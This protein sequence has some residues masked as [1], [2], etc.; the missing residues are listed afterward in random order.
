MRVIKAFGPRDLR[1]VEAPAPLSGEGE[2]LI[3]VRASGICGS[4]K[5]F[6][7]EG[8]PD[9]VAGH[10]VAG[11]VAAL[12]PGAHR[13]R[14]GDRV[15]VNNVVG[16]GR[17][18]ECRA[19]RFVRCPRRPGTDVNNGFGE[20]LTAP[21]RNC[22]LL[23]ERLCYE[24][25]CLIFDN[26][27]TPYAAL[28]A[29]GV[30]GGDD[31]VVSGCGPIGLAAVVLAK[32]RGAFV[33]AADPLAYRRDAALRLGADVV[34]AP[35]DGLPAAVRELTDGAGARV[36]LECSGKGDA[37]EAGLSCLRI[38][39]VFVAVGEG[40]EYLLRP[41]DLLIRRHLVLLGSWYTTMADGRA[42]QDLML[43]GGFD[44]SAFVTHRVSL[45]EVPEAMAR[46]CTCADEVLKTVI[47]IEK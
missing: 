24:A 15:A 4:D 36:L 40:A 32:E 1:L 12:G 18:A 5:W 13:L 17:C 28:N 35:D 31:L 30:V 8:P 38:G 39:G 26:W 23:D 16:C 6:W 3:E 27:G 29:A 47:L 37:Y 41:S 33:I 9:T 14:V 2:V 11:T 43:R 34:L 20:L 21:E 7:R 25:G 19:G 42:V 44:P 46:V 45:P 10:E 22:L